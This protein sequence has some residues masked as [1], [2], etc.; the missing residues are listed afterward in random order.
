MAPVHGRLPVDRGVCAGGEP[1]SHRARSRDGTT[2]RRTTPGSSK[3]RYSMRRLCL[4]CAAA[5]LAVACAALVPGSAAPSPDAPAK[6]A[7]GEPGPEDTLPDLDP[8]KVTPVLET[9]GHNAQVNGYFF[10]NE[11]RE[12]I[13]TGRE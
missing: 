10:T 5:L 12:L 6:S 7:A 8:S 11:E 1:V 4:I 13:T 2:G 9:G 3:V